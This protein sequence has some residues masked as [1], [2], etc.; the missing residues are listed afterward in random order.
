MAS[1]A[2]SSASTCQPSSRGSLMSSTT[3]AGRTAR[4]SSSASHA[5]GGTD[6]CDRR[7]IEIRRHQIQRCPVVVDED[8]DGE[9]H[10]RFA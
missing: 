10:R 2:L 4:I 9:T 3:A 8:D 6:T 1:S 7:A 5:V